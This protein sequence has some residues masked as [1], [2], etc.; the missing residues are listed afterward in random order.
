MI[1]VHSAENSSTTS[2]PDTGGVGKT[3]KGD[4]D[5]ED[6]RMN[7]MPFSHPDGRGNEGEGTATGESQQEP[8]QPQEMRIHDG[9]QVGHDQGDRASTAAAPYPAAV[10]ADPTGT[11]QSS[12]LQS[13]GDDN[14]AAGY[15]PSQQQ[16]ALPPLGPAMVSFNSSNNPDHEYPSRPS[17]ESVLQRLS[18]ALLRRSLT[19]VC[20]K[21]YTRVLDV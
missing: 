5:N 13:S 8:P 17:R 14:V 2:R 19:Q 4:G 6:E 16:Q 20:L 7:G 1:E 21:Y 18:E 3:D 12:I 10:A 15:P 9:Q 11:P